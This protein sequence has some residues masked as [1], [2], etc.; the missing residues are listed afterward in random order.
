MIRSGGGGALI[1]ATERFHAELINKDHDGVEH[2]FLK[3]PFQKIIFAVL[4]LPPSSDECPYIKHINLV[5]ELYEKFKNCKF[6][7][8]GGY[9]LTGITWSTSIPLQRFTSDRANKK[10]KANSEIINN[11]YAYMDL[12][13]KIS[14]LASKGYT[15][16]LLYT[17]F[18]ESDGLRVL[19]HFSQ[20][21]ETSCI[22]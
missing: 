7:L 15:L 20:T 22:L 11:A 12:S 6:L 13:Q 18:G 17:N 9:N 14:N 2:L 1:A 19:T 8:I 4:Y 3:L 21:R 10:D 5:T 16:D